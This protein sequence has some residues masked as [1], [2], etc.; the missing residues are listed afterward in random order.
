MM[1][2][3]KSPEKMPSIIRLAR[4]RS[5][6]PRKYRQKFPQYAPSPYL[7]FERRLS[8]FPEIIIDEID[9]TP[10]YPIKFKDIWKIIRI[11]F[12]ATIP[13]YL[14]SINDFLT[15][16]ISLSFVGKYGNP[17]ELAGSILANTWA[18]V[19]CLGILFSVNQGFAVVGSQL[20][21]AGRLREAGVLYQRTLIILA[22]L[23]VPIVLSMVVAEQVLIW[24]GL[25]YETSL[26]VG[27]YL[28]YL[29]PSIIS[30]SLFDCTKFFLMSQEHFYFQG[31]MQAVLVPV[32]I[33]FN[34]LFVAHKGWPVKGA[35]L[36]KSLTDFLT[37]FFLVS[38][39]HW[40]KV[41]GESWIPWTKESLKQVW[42]FL[43]QS[44][45]I[46]SNMY[47]EWISYEVSVFIASFLNDDRITGAHGIA[48]TL[49]LVIF[50]LP[51]SGSTALQAY[52]GN[53][54]GEGQKYKTQKYIAAGLCLNTFFT[55]INVLILVVFNSQVAWLFTQDEETAD[56]LR[57][58]LYIYAIAH[59]GDTFVNNLSIVL[60]TLGRERQILV[61][62]II[63]YVIINLGGQYIF[64]VL[65]KYTYVAF[66]TSYA[67]AA[68]L[69]LLS[70]IVILARM[71]WEKE[72]RGIKQRLDDYE[73]HN[74]P[75]FSPSY[76]PSKAI[77]EGADI[78]E[79]NLP[80]VPP[81]ETYNY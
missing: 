13:T 78:N 28:R 65:L 16:L 6:S 71:N 68:Y 80:L 74:S 81:P 48:I 22:I 40:S 43:V 55:L 69:M 64:G 25:N 18:N 20:F 61:N 62:F 2:T 47:V 51:Y 14:S 57:T 19:F 41:L 37:A 3:P 31:I 63:C 77:S 23:L 10:L 15:G 54:A 76:I 29:I 58:I 8:S 75:S 4:S 59:L 30:L 35:A 36:A 66:W 39:A 1:E 60:R 70:L 26:N 12:K 9:N 45:I 24:L 56:I 46:G 44:L 38:Y 11:L 50:M 7:K 53:S 49:T 21:G 79:D 67:V 52:I 73:Q 33:G 5:Y 27:L 34:F 42:Q 72:L 32:H 17:Q